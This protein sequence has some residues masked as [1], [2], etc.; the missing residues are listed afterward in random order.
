MVRIARLKDI[1]DVPNARK[2]QRTPIPIL[3]GICVFLGGITGIGVSSLFEADADMLVVVMAMTVMLYTGTIDDILGLS[4]HVRLVIEILTVLCLAGIG[5]YLLNDF[6]GL[7]GLNAIPTGVAV[8]LT[9]FAAVG[10]INAINLI[11]GVDGLSSGYCIMACV[12]FRVALP[13]RG[14]HLDG[15]PRRRL[16]RGP[17][18]SSSCTT[19]TASARRCSSATAEPSCWGSSSRSS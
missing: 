19:S 18:P 10:I 11:D 9:L 1:V 4:P 6:H 3:G 15:D 12:M 7:W 2:L 5:G 14:R 17:Y 8:P 16:G 13:P